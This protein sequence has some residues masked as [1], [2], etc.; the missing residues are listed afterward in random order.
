MT[1]AKI[2]DLPISTW[3]QVLAWY[4]ELSELAL[5]EQQARLQ[6][7]DLSEQGL[8]VLKKMLQTDQQPHILDQT[9][10]PLVEQ[11]LGE[12]SVQIHVNPKDIVGRTFGAWQTTEV[13]GSGGMG[14]VFLAQ[15][16]DGQF[17][18]KV[19]LKIIKSGGFSDLSKQRFMDEMRTLAQFEHPHIARLIDGGT[20]E[21]GIAYFVME[22]VDGVPISDYADQHQLNLK[23]RLGLVLQALEAVS[24]AHQNLV[25]HGDIKPANILVNTDG[26][27]KL[28]DFGIAQTLSDKHDTFHL[29]QFTP[30]Y[31]APEQAKGKVLTTAS[32]VFGLSAVLYELCTGSSPRKKD[33]TTTFSDYSQQLNTPITSSHLNYQNNRPAM[34]KQLGV[35]N[36]KE[37]EQALQRELGSIIDKGLQIDLNDRYQNTTDLRRE[38]LLFIQGAAVPTYANHGFYRFKKSISRHKLPVTIAILAMVSILAMLVFALNQAHLAKQE[39]QK[40]QW[41]SDF[42][43]G[44]FDEA[45]PVN[46]QQNPITV[47]ELIG[48][49]SEQM[50]SDESNDSPA[51]KLNALSLLG[52]IQFKLGQTEAA[53]N[54]HRKQIE[55]LLQQNN[56]PKA[57]AQAHFDLGMDY[58]QMGQFDQALEQYNQVNAVMPI[59]EQVTNLGVVGLQSAA[60]IYL[61]TN[62]TE[63]AAKIINQLLSMEQNILAVDLPN[64]SLASVYF[65]QARL[66]VKQEQLEAS[67]SA[68]EKARFYALKMPEP[69]PI[70]LAELYATESAILGDLKR[71]EPAIETGDKGLQL[72]KQHYGSHHP[73]TLI[74]LANYALLLGQSGNHQ[75]AIEDYK[76][77]L[78][79]I[80]HLPVPDYYEPVMSQNLAHQYRK[81]KQCELGIAYFLRA[82]SLLNTL[83]NR[84]V[85]AEVNTQSGLGR[86]YLSLNEHAASEKH[87]NQALQLISEAYGV[88]HRLYARTQA[89]QFSLWLAQKKL[90]ELQRLIP[91]TLEKLIAHDGE[92]S[93]S[94]AVT[95]LVWAIVY[96]LEGDRD[97]AQQMAQQALNTFRQNPS[98]DNHE[99]NKAAAMKILKGG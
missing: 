57:L 72:F 85:Q 79:I 23:G 29:P 93:V 50:L 56:D 35:A 26:Q 31:S 37:I 43:L 83:S 2:N 27:V 65:A 80:K 68:T 21:D 40:A 39:A 52:N 97:K 20:S 71:F 60:M 94:V 5:A 64:E 4:D 53:A 6:S 45:D 54:V 38:L 22:W 82:E 12:A 28:V 1:E 9:I 7:T 36:N 86:C 70:F 55:L 58:L 73:E 69:D 81:A 84:I 75:A 49:A 11:L 3:K 98:A 92:D 46:N 41:T 95:R 89:M 78:E 14:Q 44:I 10:D 74:A 16:A 51:I 25:V 15:R 47:N 66:Q 30:S 63:A 19:A 8:Q 77:I 76:N 62:Q 99:R 91:E 13:L 48:V 61:R 90:D 34:L 88:D 42:L 18:K 33:A 59:T 24:Y 17:D 96:D 87:F 67:L 32:D